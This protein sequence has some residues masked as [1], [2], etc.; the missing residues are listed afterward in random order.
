MLQNSKRQREEGPSAPVKQVD[1]L[2]TFDEYHRY[3]EI[4]QYINDIAELEPEWARV[5]SIG[6]TYEGR[7][8]MALE[9][10]KAGD[11]AVAN[12]LIQAGTHF[13]HFLAIYFCS[14]N[15]CFSIFIGV[16]AREWIAPAVTTYTIYELVENYL[17]HPE[18]ADNFNFF[19]IPNGN[20]DGYEY[21]W[22]N[23]KEFIS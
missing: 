2:L 20:P 9:L 15:S 14:E 12:I 5:V 11:N 22:V 3:D 4:V 16:H 8:M 19:I 10:S 18:Y 6:P 13:W 21:T 17:A 1:S 23:R 7:D